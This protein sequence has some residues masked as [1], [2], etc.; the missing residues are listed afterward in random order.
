MKTTAKYLVVALTFLAI[1]GATQ[2]V[3]C[4]AAHATETKLR[5][6][7]PAEQWSKE[8]KLWLSRS[9]IGEAGWRR[10][11]EYSAI[12][13]VYA[14]R[15]E[16]SSRYT[17]LRMIKRY[18]A[19]V[20]R[21]GRSRNPWL[22]ELG[23]DAKRPPSWP[24]DPVTRY[25]PVWRVHKAAWVETLQWAD[26]WAAG[27]HPN[28]CPGANHFGGRMDVYRAVAARWKRIRC[29]VETGNRFYTSLRLVSAEQAR[30]G[31]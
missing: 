22:F 13:W 30:R 6:P 25:G 29:T 8:A 15:S 12:A 11:G 24:I 23:L 28:T 3:E 5:R 18:S 19:A 1:V 20:R 9:V 27:K 21:P 26:E 7:V 31:G 14:T 16:H 2:A 4:K 17:F 10:F